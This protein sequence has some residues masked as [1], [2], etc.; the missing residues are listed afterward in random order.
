VTADLT[1]DLD[2]DAVVT[3]PLAGTPSD[4]GG[5]VGYAEVECFT[6]QAAGKGKNKLVAYPGTLHAG[7]ALGTGDGD[8]DCD[9]TLSNLT[10]GFTIPAA[11][12][13]LLTGRSPAAHLFYGDASLGFVYHSGAPLLEITDLLPPDAIVVDG[14]DLSID[15]SGL[16]LGC[17]AG[18]VTGGRTFYA[19]AHVRR[20]T[21]GTPYAD[22]EHELTAWVD[23]DGTL[24]EDTYSVWENPAGGCVNGQLVE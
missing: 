9:E 8:G 2:L 11:F 12:E 19:R 13:Y 20:P 18:V 22:T 7:L 21:S 6:S 10:L 3:A 24:V 14:G 17:G 4:P 15:L 23:V 16:D 5:A 1:C